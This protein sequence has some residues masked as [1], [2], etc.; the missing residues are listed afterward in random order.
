VTRAIWDE[1]ESIW[2]ISVEGKGEFSAEIIVN[3]GGILNNP[4]MPTIKG[5]D[6]FSGDF[7]HTAQ[8]DPKVNL[9]G[10]SIAL[11][12]AGASAIQILPQIQPIA[13]HIDLYIRTPSW[14]S[15]P[16]GAPKG[17]NPPYTIEEQ[18]RF[19]DD[20]VFSLTTRKTLESSFNTMFKAFF[21]GTDQQKDLRNKFETRMKEL[22][23]DPEL[24]KK[25]IPD[26]EVGCRRI[27]PGEA[28]LTSLQNDNVAPIFGPI[29]EIVTDGVVSNGEK[30]PAD[31]IVAA[32]G[33][34]TG[35]RPRFPII[36]RNGVN[37]QDLWAKEPTSYLGTG[38]SGYPNYLIFLGPNTPISNGSITGKF[39]S[40]FGKYR[41]IADARVGPLEATADYFSKLIRKM[42]TQRAK[43]FDVRPEAQLDFDE[44]TQRFMKNMVWT[45][46]CRSWCK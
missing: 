39:I 13:R 8:W 25:L 20:P 27:N 31:V 41:D 14:I 24:Q 11:I 22:I 29:S 44:H 3:A 23:P 36:G 45:G 12:G 30:R 18:E 37:L 43:S 21:K 46:T 4:Q 7:L 35:F 19:R 33:F 10:K 26:F 28:Y 2:K 9:E 40:K 16:I 15:P 38:V 1:T 5:L 17:K 32:T 6:T 34:N 42:H